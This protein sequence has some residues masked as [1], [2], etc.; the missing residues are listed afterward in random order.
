MR[1]VLTYGLTLNQGNNPMYTANINPTTGIAYG[2]IAA[3][4]L[5]SDLVNELMD[6]GTDTYAEEAFAAW[7][8]EKANQI[9][10]DGEDIS[11]EDAKDEA[12]DLSY[13]FWDSY[14][15]DEPIIEGVHEG[16]TYCSS[17]PGGALNFFI[18]ES[19][20]TTTKARLASP[21]IPNAGILDTLD[22]NVIAYDV[23]ADWRRIE[24]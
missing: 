7:L 18:Y 24:D 22:G 11:D 4:A 8:E 12:N 17:W 16:V 5:D 10:A 1:L 14:E 20:V 21:C 19:P 23:P 6:N 9:Q 15:S 2:Y 3:S 13:Q